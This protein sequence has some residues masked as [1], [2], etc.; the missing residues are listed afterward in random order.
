MHIDICILYVCIC[1]ANLAS[2]LTNKSLAPTITSPCPTPSVQGYL[3][4]KKLPPP[5]TLQ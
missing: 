5:R 4:H 2:F 1:T 3:A